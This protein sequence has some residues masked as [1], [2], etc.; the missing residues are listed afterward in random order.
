M[1]CKDERSCMQ[2]EECIT[3]GPKKVLF[4]SISTSFGFILLHI[5]KHCKILP[6]MVVRD[7][8]AGLRDVYIAFDRI[9]IYNSRSVIS[10]C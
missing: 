10:E 3:A 2:L 4:S 6:C 7:N 5:S 8:A 1:A 9:S